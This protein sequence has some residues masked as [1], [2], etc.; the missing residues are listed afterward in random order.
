MHPGANVIKHFIRNLQTSQN[1]LEFCAWQSLYS[2]V[3]Y[4]LLRPEPTRVEHL[5]LGAYP[6]VEHRRVLQ[7]LH[8]S[9]LRPMHKL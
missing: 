2:L 3:Y 8:K 9:R 7:V 4:L 1:K 6:K 5:R